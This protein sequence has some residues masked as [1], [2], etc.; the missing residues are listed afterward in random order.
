VT[1]RTFGPLLLLLAILP[2]GCGGPPSSGPAP[3]D[4]NRK[5]LIAVIPKGT[6]HEFWKSVHHG[7]DRAAKELGVE[8]VWKGAVNESDRQAQKNVVQ[9]FINQ[10]VDGI[11]LA[12]NSDEA[13]VDDVAL[14]KGRGI[15]TV[16]FDSGLKSPENY[17]SYVATDNEHGGVLAAQTLAKAMGDEGDVVMLRYAQGS[18]S[19]HLREEGFLKEMAKHPKIKIISS[20]QYSNTTRDSSFVVCQNLLTDFGETVDGVY[21]V[22]EPNNVGMLNALI[23][24]GLVKKVKFV[25]F[26]PGPQLI[27]AMKAGQIQGLVLQDPD[28]IGYLAVKTVVEHIRGRTVP[29]RIATGEFVATPENMDSPEMQ[30]LLHPPQFE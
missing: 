29:K 28:R 7:A 6:T 4:P 3:A 30:R 17:V 11:C 5:L 15:P 1:H 14:A 13:L 23:D 19:T 20:N 10:G 12:P 27:T 21:T 16:I 9:D 2:A 25:G 26:D 8:I 18:E 22:A 24:K